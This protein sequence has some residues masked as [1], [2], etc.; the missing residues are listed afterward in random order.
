[1]TKLRRIT[2]TGFSPRTS[3][4]TEFQAESMDRIGNPRDTI[5]EGGGIWEELAGGRIATTLDF[6][7]IIDYILSVSECVNWWSG[8]TI[9]IFITSVFETE[10]NNIIGCIQN[11]GSIDVASI[12]IP[13]IPSQSWKSSL[14]KNQRVFH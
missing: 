13:R 1:M 3:V 9:H 7:A 6:P 14:S 4:E 11:L 8:L 12:G 10:I 2:S 5:R